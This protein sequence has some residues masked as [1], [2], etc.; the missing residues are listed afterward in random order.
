MG[1]AQHVG[2]GVGADQAVDQV[3]YGRVLQ[4]HQVVRAR[5]VSGRRAKVVVQLGARRQGDRV[6]GDD[7]VVIARHQPVDVLGRV[8]VADVQGHADLGQVALPR[9]QQA[10]KARLAI[11]ERERQR[12]ALAIDQAVAFGAPAGLFEQGQGLQLLLT[13]DPRAV[14]DRGSEHRG[15]HFIWHLAAQGGEQLQLT[16]IRQLA[17]GQ[18]RIGE[19]ALLADVQVAHHL[20]VAPL[21]VP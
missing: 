5:V 7:H 21:E 3:V 12:R 9:Q 14:G 18:R 17:S 1:V 19:H 15:E 10:F 20:P 6:A 11:E 2:L 4:D 8:D 16:R 13:D